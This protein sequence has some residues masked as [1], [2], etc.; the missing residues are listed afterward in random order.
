MRGAFLG[1]LVGDALT[2]GTHYEYDAKKVIGVVWV[3]VDNVLYPHFLPQNRDA[4]ASDQAFT[5]LWTA[6]TPLSTLLPL[7]TLM[8]LLSLLPL[9]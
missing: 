1:A 2:L 7:L 8:Y 4:H 6:A 9:D 5:R 3:L